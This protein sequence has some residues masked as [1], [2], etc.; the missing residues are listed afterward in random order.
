MKTFV[1]RDL[2]TGAFL[3]HPRNDG[4]PATGL[5]P[6]LV[7]YE[8]LQQDIPTEFDPATHHVVR[9]EDVIDE[10]ARTVTRG[11]AVVE[12]P[13]APVDTSANTVDKTALFLELS[14][15]G[16]FS[17]LEAIVGGILDP[18]VKEEAL[19][20]MRYAQ[21]VDRNHA[22]VLGLAQQLNLDAVAMDEIFAATK[23]REATM[24]QATLNLA[25]PPTP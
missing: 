13:P 12:H 25:P 17:T 8:V 11:W 7:E 15:R 3:R 20:W 5:D 24:A 16:L 10:E 1:I 19:I 22:I 6:G 2:T 4:T 23:V 21:T 14:S 18:Q 9:G